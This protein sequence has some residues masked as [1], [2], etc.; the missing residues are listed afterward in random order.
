VRHLVLPLLEEYFPDATAIL[1]RDARLLADD[2]AWLRQETG[3]AWARCAVVEDGVVLLDRAA[4][5]AMDRAL[6][7]RVV[8]RAWLTVRGLAAAVG[9]GAE[10]VEAAREAIVA[11]R[12]GG[13]W[14]LPGGV[15]VL[16]E[17]ATAAIGPATTLE[18][19]LR[20]RLRLPLVAPGWEVAL[21]G[22][23]TIDLPDGWG[24]RI[25]EGRGGASTPGTLH[26]PA[27]REAPPLPLA[28]RTWRDGDRLDL[29]NGRGSQKVQDWFVDHRVPRYA[30]RHLVLLAAGRRVLWIAGLG[31][32]L[33]ASAGGDGGRAAGGLTLRLLYNGVPVEGQG[34]PGD[35]A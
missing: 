2:E 27:G 18:R 4:F 6:Q 32:F 16:V 15:A 14:A 21:A 3:R 24:V 9:L 25:D 28:L 23:G 22:P 19:A 17:R 7:R 29:P 1:S 30:R 34:R 10:P 12:S 8:R 35:R 11:G 5:R 33:P 13:R 20:R 31:A 26:I